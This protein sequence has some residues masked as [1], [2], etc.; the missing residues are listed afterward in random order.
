MPIPVRLVVMITLVPT[1]QIVEIVIVRVGRKT[2]IAL[3]VI[4]L[5]IPEN[6]N[7]TDVIAAIAIVVAIILSQMNV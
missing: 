1:G 4:I 6:V 7:L 2:I 5:K 3:L